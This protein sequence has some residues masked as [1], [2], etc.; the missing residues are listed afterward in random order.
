[1]Y[2]VREAS[3]TLATNTALAVGLTEKKLHLRNLS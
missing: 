3:I 1:M 2:N